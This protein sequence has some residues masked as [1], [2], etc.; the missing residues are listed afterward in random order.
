MKTG[1][2]LVVAVGF[3][4]ALARLAASAPLADLAGVAYLLTATLVFER[5]RRTAIRVH[6]PA[7]P[8]SL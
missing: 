5:E 6:A 7:S 2:L 1:W 4:A 8:R 3:A